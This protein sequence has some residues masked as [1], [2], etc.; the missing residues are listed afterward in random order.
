MPGPEDQPT[1][2]MTEEEYYRGYLDAHPGDPDC[3]YCCSRGSTF[4]E[5][6]GTTTTCPHCVES[7]Y[8][9]ASGEATGKHLEGTK[10]WDELMAEKKKLDAMKRT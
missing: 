2:Y 5:A 8:L 7:G 10:F 9:T 6:T 3:D 4:D 1:D